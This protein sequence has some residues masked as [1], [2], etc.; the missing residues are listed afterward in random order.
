MITHLDAFRAGYASLAQ[1]RADEP[2]HKIA[3]GSPFDW[4][5]QS[6][7]YG[8]EVARVYRFTEPVPGPE[9]KGVISCKPTPRLVRGV[10]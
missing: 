3:A 9:T 8:W 6:P 10:E 7:M 2:R 5:G 4:D 1:W